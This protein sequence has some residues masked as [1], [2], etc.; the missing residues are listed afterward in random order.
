[1]TD[2]KFA[3]LISNAVAERM[4]PEFV[5]KAIVERVDKLIDSAIND[6]FRSYSDTAKLIETAV[7]DSLKINRLEIHSFGEVVSKVLERQIHDICSETLAGKL[8]GRMTE[9]LNMA[10]KKIKLSKIVEDMIE[11]GYNED[12]GEVVTCIVEHDTPRD[13]WATV[14]LDENPN[15]E[16]D[17]CDVNMRIYKGEIHSA[18]LGWQNRHL[19]DLRFVGKDYGIESVIQMYFAAGTIIE[20]DDDEVSTYRDYD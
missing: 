10:P 13:D 6:A 14:Y 1:M 20:L 8:S 3:D 12:Y 19:K 18:V 5:E 2:S 17:R 11:H 9:L 7:Q 4:Q 16:K 15:T